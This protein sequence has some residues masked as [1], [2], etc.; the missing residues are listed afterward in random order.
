MIDL[1]I[2]STASDGT[3]SPQ[4]IVKTA[5]DAAINAIAITD[6]DTIDGVREVVEAGIPQSL[7][8]I[9]GIE[10]SA[11]PPPEFEI[12]GSLHIL[13]YGI[14]IYDRTLN[15]TLEQLKKARADRNPKIIQRLN[16]LG[17]EI[18]LGEVEQICGPG[19]T[20]RPH[21]AQA[22]VKKGFVESFDQAFDQF[23]ATGRPA[24]VDKER[25]SCQ[26][27]ITLILDAGGLPVLAHPGLIDPGDNR[28]IKPLV[29]ALADMGLKGIE[30]YY[31]DHSE[32]QT[33]YFAALAAQ[34]GLFST[35]GSDFH[36]TMKQG[37]TMGRGKGNLYVADDLYRILVREIEALQDADPRLEI[38]EK[39]LGH[40][41]ANRELLENALRH[42]SYVNE[43]QTDQIPDN[44]RLEFMGDAVL[45][46]TIGQILMDEHPGMNEGSLSKAR[47]SLVSEPALASMARQIDLGRFI[48]LGKGEK[49]SRGAEKNSILADAFEAVMAAIYLD[50]GFKQTCALVRNQFI[51]QIKQISSAPE[52]EDFKS[53]L[54]EFVQ[55]KGNTPPCYTI[56]GEFGPDHD[57][58][59]SVCVKACDIESMG[60]GKS[61]KAAE[62]NAAQNALKSLKKLPC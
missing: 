1:H 47:A 15:R 6:H 5:V 38:L 22:M 18:T 48:R 26:A 3:L 43:L 35:G 52:I 59:F 16:Q 54:Q 11:T 32:E 60:S 50:C 4:E 45:G 30:V 61:K 58:T 42:S 56:H 21:I 19:Q 37:T 46:L 40:T 57:K 9:T 13:G 25:L 53:M 12:N 27:A 49:L 51:S 10:I 33:D 44:Q 55:E 17:F 39:N 34:K 23:L 24:H 14:S 8:L 62:Q 20:G 29:T 41:F 36:G 7:E 2:H 28:S 31:T